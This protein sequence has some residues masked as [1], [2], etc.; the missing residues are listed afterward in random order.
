MKPTK[1]IEERIKNTL[2]K[3]QKVLQIAKDRDLNESDTVSIINDI[4]ADVFGYEKYTEITS[5]LMIRGTFCDLAIR[6][7]GK[8]EDGFLIECKRVGIELKEEHMRQAVNYGVNKG[9]NWVILTNGIIWKVYKLKF[10]QP[11]SWDL[12]LTVD[13][14]NVNVKDDADIENLFVICKEGVLKSAREELYEKVQ[15]VNRFV[16]G[17]LILNEPVLSVIRKELRKMSDGINVA[18]EEIG[19][20]IRTS[21]LK[22]DI[23]DEE[24]S[25]TQMAMTRVAKFYKQSIKKHEKK[26]VVVKE[27]NKEPVQEMSVADKL[28]KEAESQSQTEERSQNGNNGQS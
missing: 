1:K 5:E 4:L 7:N 15:C 23:V 25:E 28:L 24:Q 2:P 3:F 8:F 19:E 13:L 6:L 18:E 27:E 14:L 9:I 10:E 26:E 20:I 16:I 17:Q 11:V 21:V 22:R 12:V